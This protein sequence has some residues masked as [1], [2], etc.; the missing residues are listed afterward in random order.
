MLILALDSATPVAGVALWEDGKLL[1][2]EFVNYKKTHSETL[3]P[4]VDQVLTGCEK[5]IQDVSAMALTI[6][7]GSFTGLRI[8][9][10]AIKGISLATGIPVVG[11]STL[12]VMAHNFAYSK[13]LVCPLLDA[14]KQEVYAG[15]FDMSAGYPKKLA[16]EIACSPNEFMA[17]ALEKQALYD[18]EKIILLGD[19]YFPYQEDFLKEL[20]DQCIIAPSHLMLPRASALADL[21]VSKV[22]QK[23]YI[24]MMKL[25]PIYLRLSEAEYRL[26]KGEL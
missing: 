26:G 2:E 18:K 3:M 23:E 14:R 4:M 25:R 15:F 12:E 16:E 5:R 7:P 20:G 19:G 9:M 11:F 6:G 1:R 21:A 17:M 24:D 8:G 22:E 13:A 10:A